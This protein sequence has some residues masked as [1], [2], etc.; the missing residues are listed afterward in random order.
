MRCGASPPQR[1][2]NSRRRAV[3][4]RGTPEQ[5]RDHEEGL[6]DAGVQ[7]GRGIAR[8]A[9]GCAGG[10][11]GGEELMGCRGAGWGCLGVCPRGGEWRGQGTSGLGVVV[12]VV[13]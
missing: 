12:V 3:G 10:R 11:K 13:V 4:G 6:G 5:G 1:L 2:P 7:R 9:G 8:L